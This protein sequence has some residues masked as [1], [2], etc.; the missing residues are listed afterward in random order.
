[1]SFQDRICKAFCADV[2]V[3]AFRGGYGVSTPFRGVSGDQIGYYIVGP[4]ERGLY[5]IIDDALTVELFEGE[6][7]TLNASTRMA[8]FYSILSAHG[9]HYDED[10]GEI[11]T[12]EL[13]FDQLDRA[14]ID[15]MAMLLRLQDMYFLTQERTESTF[16]EDFEARLEKASPP[17]LTVERK[18][19][20]SDRLSDV[21]AD[22]L[23]KGAVQ[24]KPVALFLVTHTEKL[25]QAMYLRSQADVRMD[26]PLS[27]V[28][29][30]QKHDTG[31]AKMR[32]KASNRLDAL[33]NWEGDEDAA[34]N[35]V[36]REAGIDHP[37]VH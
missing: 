1:M 35:R 33:A 10:T 28:A 8:T 22:Y 11:S 34:L 13:S 32:A 14:S 2:K 24:T 27:V 3:N 21:E 18:A 29:L 16:Y 6:G 17:G 26:Q 5:R 37:L 12:E 20:V 30:L 25:W 9:G 4:N 31:T 19:I 23:I 7:A 36:L 15:F